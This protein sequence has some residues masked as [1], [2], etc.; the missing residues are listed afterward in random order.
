MEVIAWNY[1]FV[2]WGQNLSMEKS[3]GKL[4]RW[5]DNQD[6]NIAEIE[7]SHKEKAGAV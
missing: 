1:K 5:I 2:C 4:I 3:K 6:A 7:T